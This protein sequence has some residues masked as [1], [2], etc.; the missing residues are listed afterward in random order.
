MLKFRTL[1]LALLV[2]A[3]CDSATGPS[4]RTTL[5]QARARWAAQGGENY[6]VELTRSCE[7][8]LAGRRM[9]VTV[10][11][12]SVASAEYFESGD[13]VAGAELSYV[14]TVEDLF[15]LIEDA[16]AQPAAAFLA[17]YDEQYGYPTRIEIDPSATTADDEVS[18]SVRDL[19]LLSS[20]QAGR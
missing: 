3:A 11:N 4:E 9:L 20:L 2:L 5:A 12:G 14:P 15:D 6:T 8:I 7:C 10:Q 16:L 1:P 18:W 19:V 13:P 17:T